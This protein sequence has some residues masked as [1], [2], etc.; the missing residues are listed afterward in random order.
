[1]YQNRVTLIGFLGKD[2]EVK[3]TRNNA[4]F[5][6]AVAGHQAQLEEPRDRRAPVR[7]DL[8]PLHRLGQARRVRGHAHQGRARQI[9]GEIRTR[10]YTQKPAARNPWT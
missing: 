2:A 9:E 5:H 1:M 3:S 6:R 8:A 7:D 10:E 4:S